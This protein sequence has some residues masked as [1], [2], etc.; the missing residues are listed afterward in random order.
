MTN[1]E[2]AQGLVNAKFATDATLHS[3]QMVP[4]NPTTAKEFIEKTTDAMLESK[5]AVVGGSTD[6]ITST[7]VHNIA[8]T[9][10]TTIPRQRQSSQRLGSSLSPR[11]GSSPGPSA[12]I[13]TWTSLSQLRDQL[14]TLPLD[15]LPTTLWMCHRY[16]DR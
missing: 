3:S 4:V 1:Q 5:D 13:P 11:P 6:A 15:A 10:N 7:G 14:P 16:N 2:L 12:L 8:L 9:D